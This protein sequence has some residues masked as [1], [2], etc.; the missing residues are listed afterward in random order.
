MSTGAEPSLLL[1]NRE[2]SSL[3]KP[4]PSVIVLPNRT[5]P[6][7]VTITNA[8]GQIAGAADFYQ[9]GLVDGDDVNESVLGGSGYD[10]QAAGVQSFPVSA[11]DAVM[12]F[13]LSTHDRWS[14]AA[15]NEYDIAIDTNGDQKADFVVIGFDLGALTTGSFDGR[16]AVFRLNVA[17]GALSPL[18]LASAPTD[19]STV[20]LPIYASQLGLTPADG[21]FT[22]TVQTFS[23][24]G[25]GA[26]VMKGKAGFNP[27]KP[28]LV[29]FP[30][31]VVA[32]GGSVDVEVSFDVTAF[33]QQPRG[34]MVVSTD[35][36]AGAEVQLI[37]VPG[38][39]KGR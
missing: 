39:K 4:A 5:G 10:L 1:P 35:D 21:D 30:Y 6:H 9:W 32:P 36:A 33:S 22:Y 38:K 12:V 15:V 14:N 25:A 18:F 16:L 19:S 24:E 23:L 31:E 37:E 2:T 17:T 7:E 11:T 29:D 20:L 28:A 3:N 27:F 26:D 34:I 8:G 13:A